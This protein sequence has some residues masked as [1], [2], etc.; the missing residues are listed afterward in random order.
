M[1]NTFGKG[2]AGQ[3]FYFSFS[4]RYFFG[5]HYSSCKKIYDY[6]LPNEFDEKDA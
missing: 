2:I 5:A 1:K 6:S 3:Y 4:G